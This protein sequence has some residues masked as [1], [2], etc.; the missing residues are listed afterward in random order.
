MSSAAIS[1]KGTVLQLSVSGIFTTIVEQV[2]IA[3]P[4]YKMSPIDVT[5]HD[6]ISNFKEIIAGKKDAGTISF[7]GNYIPAASTGI[8]QV[9]RAALISGT[10]GSWKLIR[11][12]SGSET[13]AFSA[14]VTGFEVDH[15]YSKQITVKGTLEITGVPAISG[16]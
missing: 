10:V 5:S 11:P 8:Q 15:D 12:D 14:Y 7:E 2:K 13:E 9:V 6:S 3:G 1:A 16:S 4:A